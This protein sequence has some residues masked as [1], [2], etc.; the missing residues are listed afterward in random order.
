MSAVSSR[1]SSDTQFSHEKGFGR[2]CGAKNGFDC[3]FGVE[4]FRANQIY[5]KLQRLIL[6]R[7]GDRGEQN[8]APPRIARFRETL[9]Q[10]MEPLDR[11][12]SGNRKGCFSSGVVGSGKETSDPRDRAHAFDMQDSA[13]ASPEHFGLVSAHHSSQAK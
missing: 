3:S 5:Q 10:R 11:M 13:V 8:R 7:E 4:R 1:S 2:S 9:P 6:T 12:R